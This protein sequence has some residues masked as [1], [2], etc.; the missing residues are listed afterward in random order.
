MPPVCD[1][2]AGLP[3]D[4]AANFRNPHSG[5]RCRPGVQS[6]AAIQ[7]RPGLGWGNAQG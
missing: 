6:D 4:S 2:I 1:A 3:S 7:R 5:H